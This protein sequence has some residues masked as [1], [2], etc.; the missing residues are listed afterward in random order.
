MR[1][2]EL[3]RRLG[4]V[5]VGDDAEAGPWALDSREI[6]PGSVFVAIK[7][8][9]VDGIAFADQ[10]LRAGACAVV[11]EASV[12]G[13]HIRVSSV[14]EALAN[15]GRSLRA[16]FE[17]PVVA[18]TGSNGKTSTKE[19]LASALRPLGTI[20][21]SE[22]NQNTEYTSPLL[23]SRRTPGTV[24]AI[25]EMGMR[26]PGQIAHL[27]NIASPTHAL[28]TMIGTAHIE[29]LGSREGIARAKGEVLEALPAHG[30]AF[31]NADDPLTAFLAAFSQAPVKTFGFAPG[32]DLQIVG[33]RATSLQEMD[34]RI[35]YQGQTESVTLPTVG[36][37][38]SHNA[39]AALLTAVNLGLSLSQASNALKE[40]FVSPPMR[41]EIRAFRGAEVLLDTYNASPDS[42]VAALVTFAEVPCLGR[43]IVVLGEMKELGAMTELGH[44]RVGQQLADTPFDRVILI[45]EPTRYMAE[46][47]RMRGVSESCISMATSMEDVRRELDLVQPGDRVLIKGSRA[48]ALEQLMEGGE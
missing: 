43:R 4:G 25:V 33:Y 2:S 17:G 12:N 29:M 21:K 47:A 31:L 10:V 14:V 6:I 42:T 20:L 19:M 26:G 45:G 13:P 39:A 48:L 7:G 23:W 32:S 30:M 16:E 9:R 44:R 1:L 27:A 36:R 34:L 22:G 3:A 24:A 28:I 37:H 11:A 15:Y 38:Q 8:E 40:N 35:A 41:M 18:I 5:L 46:E